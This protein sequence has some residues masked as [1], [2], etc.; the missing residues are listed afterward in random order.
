MELRAAD[1]RFTSGE[2]AMLLQQATSRVLDVESLASLTARTEGWAVGLQLAGLSLQHHED[3]RAFV[4]SFSGTHR[5]VLDFLTE[6]VLARQPAERVRFLLETLGLSSVLVDELRLSIETAARVRDMQV[7][8]AE[9]IE[10]GLNNCG[11]RSCRCHN[12]PFDGT[13]VDLLPTGACS[14]TRGSID[15]KRLSVKS[16]PASG[17]TS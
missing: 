14:R 4:A 3:P 11:W 16:A 7:S 8:T 15:A 17:G 5:Y 9:L 2:A 6:E 12:F 10:I 13:N 1:L